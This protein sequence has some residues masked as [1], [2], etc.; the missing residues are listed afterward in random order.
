MYLYA[1]LREAWQR[2][3]HSAL[4]ELGEA[5][6]VSVSE[7]RSQGWAE[8]DSLQDEGWGAARVLGE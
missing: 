6:L 3:H 1:L 5:G 8:E 2:G 7:L 4:R